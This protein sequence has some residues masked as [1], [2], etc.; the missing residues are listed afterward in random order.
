[1]AEKVYLLILECHT[2]DRFV[3]ENINL[4]TT[5]QRKKDMLA[6]LPEAGIKRV[7]IAELIE[8][9]DVPLPAKS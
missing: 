5:R 9:Y 8:K 3:Y 6:D 1:M 2:G 4:E 7:F